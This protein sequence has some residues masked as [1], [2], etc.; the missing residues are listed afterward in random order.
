MTRR[1]PRLAGMAVLAIVAFVPACSP[2]KAVL[3]NLPPETTVFVQGPVSA[4]NHNVH[5]YWF[6]SDPDGDVVAYR[7]RFLD[8][9]Q[10]PPPPP[11]WTGTKLDWLRASPVW[12]DTTSATDL[13]FTLQT[14]QNDTIPPVF[15]VA[16]IDDDWEPD[17]SPAVEQFRFTNKPPSIIFTNAPRATDQTY[18]SLTLRWTPFDPDGD[19]GKMTYRVWLNGNAANALS[20]PAGVT[21]FTLPSVHFTQGDSL[22]PAADSVAT[23]TVYVQ[24]IDDG[25]RAGPLALAQWRVRK[26]TRLCSW[27]TLVD[28]ENARVLLIDDISSD[29]PA[30]T[31]S[32][33]F[34]RNGL[35][36]NLPTGKFSYLRLETTQPFQS[37]QD[38]V[39][40]LSLFKAVI[41]Y[42][43][44]QTVNTNSSLS[45]TPAGMVNLLGTHQAALGAYLD[46]NG[47][48]MLEGLNLVAQGS[49]FGPLGASFM[50]DYLET[51]Q[52]HQSFNQVTL[53]STAVWTT[54]QDDPTRGIAATNLFS[55]RL[56]ENMKFTQTVVGLRGFALRDTADGLFWAPAGSLSEGNTIVFPAA[57]SVP[58]A[59]TGRM[60]LVSY[61]MASGLGLT[62]GA[63]LIRKILRDQLQVSP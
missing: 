48:L 38:V 19:T 56:G 53:D 63:S 40:T 21:Q 1:A 57:I 33:N 35:R 54:R 42:R 39:Q 10:T 7:Y 60:L 18:Y 47:R 20:V 28:P 13:I 25:G 45:K 49:N 37:A 12:D 9:L 31:A 24:P 27:T 46:A 11:G 29:E 15:E 6:G 50:S 30:N 22:P 41:W 61:P 26:P 58:Q 59:A 34:Y 52:L 43:G 17:P 23:R 14:G 32:D 2:K 55:S 36:D 3:G 16:A 44:L 62:N 51:I 4:V 5:L 8:T